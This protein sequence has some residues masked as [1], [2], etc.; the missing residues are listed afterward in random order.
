VAAENRNI[1]KKRDSL[2]I[3]LNSRDKTFSFDEGLSSNPLSIRREQQYRLLQHDISLLENAE[4]VVAQKK[5]P[6]QAEEGNLKFSE[7]LQR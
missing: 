6:P 2:N 3:T 5:R 4:T 1:K 7:F